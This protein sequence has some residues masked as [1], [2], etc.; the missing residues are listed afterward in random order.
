VEAQRRARNYQ[1]IDGIPAILL[2]LTYLLFAGGL[3]YWFGSDHRAIGA[4]PLFSMAVLFLL[5]ER[6]LLTWFRTRV[7]YRRTGY[8][9]PPNHSLPLTTKKLSGARRLL[10]LMLNFVSG[11]NWWVMLILFFGPRWDVLL[12]TVWLGVK[13]LYLKD[14]VRGEI[15]WLR[16]FG[17]DLDRVKRAEN[18]KNRSLKTVVCAGLLIAGWTWT[19]YVSAL[20][21]EEAWLGVAALILFGINLLKGFDRSEW[22]W[23]FSFSLI[24]VAF[25]LAATH[26]ETGSR[27]QAALLLL[28]PGILL[29]IRGTLDLVRYLQRNPVEQ[30]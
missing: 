7:T 5:N 12:L 27:H 2:S 4:I 19:V 28:S 1:D 3:I 30:A 14:L 15:T 21:T 20:L 18:L 13:L 11:I 16:F 6:K 29:T 8:A 26:W 17:L 23:V 24:S 9:A 22:P 25:A 10:L